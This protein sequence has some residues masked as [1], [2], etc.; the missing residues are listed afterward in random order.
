M[1]NKQY[2]EIEIAKIVVP[3]KRATATFTKAQHR[4]L[5]ASITENGFNIP[6]L[7]KPLPEGRYEL[8]D[9]LH[10]IQI[11]NEMGWSKIP[12]MIIA[13]DEKKAAI[14]NFLANT[15]RGTQNPVDVAEALDR[16]KQAGATVEELAAATGHTKDWVEFYLILVKL[17][18]VHKD[19]L[20]QGV[21]KTGVVKEALRLP[22]PEDTDMLLGEAIQ[23]GWTVGQVKTIVDRYVADERVKQFR[24]G[25]LT[26]PE[27]LPKFDT[28]RLIQYDEC[29]TCKR[30]V[31][32]GQTW[33]KV[34]C[35]DCLTL[36]T[37]LTGNLGDPKEALDTV[38]KAL[39]LK[40]QKDKFDKLKEKFEPK[41]KKEQ[42]P[43]PPESGFPGP[44]S[45]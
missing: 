43:A 26:K 19:A 36:L 23:M 32:K 24:K 44:T 18:A 30:K 6:I 15:A 7:V 45:G 1:P 40:M 11:V 29:M 16:T 42:P 9:G 17:P 5:K 13:A 25:E 4:E 20:R 22:R 35:N 2:Q 31:P 41:T 3:E 37:Y 28:K 34:I 10:R 33:M 38:Y 8:I 21:L 12:A 27:E 14:L 39:S